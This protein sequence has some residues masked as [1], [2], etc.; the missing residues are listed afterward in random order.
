MLKSLDQ[1][2][3]AI[4]LTYEGATTFKT[5]VGG[6]FT[7]LSGI[8]VLAFFIIQLMKVIEK[9]SDVITLF[10]FRQ[11]AVERLEMPLDTNK[12]DIAFFLYSMYPPA[13]AQLHRYMYGKIEL[14]ILRYDA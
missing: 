1:F 12:F 4:N 13:A 5:K 14:S 2:G 8:G 10:N 9:Q 3:H 11:V 6:F 7:I